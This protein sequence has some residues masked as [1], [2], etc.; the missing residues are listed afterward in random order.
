MTVISEEV[1]KEVLGQAALS[2]GELDRRQRMTDL[3]LIP[4]IPRGF[5]EMSREY[6]QGAGDVLVHM[7][8]LGGA[9]VAVLDKVGMPELTTSAILSIVR[10]SLTMWVS[11]NHNLN[12]GMSPAE[13][14][15][16]ALDFLQSEYAKGFLTSAEGSEEF[17]KTLDLL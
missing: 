15:Q 10:V 7:A 9:A 3:A 1:Y 6:A 12:Q 13:A 5:D 14:R 8:S 11:I 2:I 4:K 17:P 16:T